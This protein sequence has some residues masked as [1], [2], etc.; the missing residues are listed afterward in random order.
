MRGYIQPGN[1][2]TLPAPYAVAANKTTNR[3][4]IA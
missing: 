3:I 2:I 4:T 1:T